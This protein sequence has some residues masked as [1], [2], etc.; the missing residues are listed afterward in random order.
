ML[1]QCET[2]GFRCRILWEDSEDSSEGPL[3]PGRPWPFSGGFAFLSDGVTDITACGVMGECEQAECEAKCM[4]FVVW[5]MWR[6]D[7]KLPV[8]HYSSVARVPVLAP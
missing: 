8:R 1:A 6:N 5:R 7:Q 4:F 2:Q 3:F